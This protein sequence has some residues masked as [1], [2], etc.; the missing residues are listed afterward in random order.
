MFTFEIRD[1]A[2][3]TNTVTARVSWIDKNKPGGTC[4]YNPADLAPTAD[5]VT[6]TLT[7]FTKPGTII[8]NN[9]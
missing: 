7:D 9:Q 8:T 3:N 4:V 5:P 1:L 6:A 2:G